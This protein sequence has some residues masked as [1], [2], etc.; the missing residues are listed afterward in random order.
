MTT[1]DVVGSPAE[2]PAGNNAESK[3]DQARKHPALEWLAKLG[4][5][6]YGVM[7][8]VVGWLALQIAFGD[9]AGEA[10]GHGA[11]REIARQPFGEVLLWVACVGFAALVAWKACEAV[12]G[13]RAEDGGK[14]VAARAASAAKAV[15][16]AVLAVLAFQTVTGSSRGGGRRSSEEGYT[17]Q[18]LQMPLGPALVVGLGVVIGGYGFYSIYKGLSDG[19]RKSLEAQGWT[20]DIGRAVTVLARTGYSTRGL[21]FGVIGG[22]FVWAGLT[23]DA[24]KSGGLDQALQTLQDAPF[25][26]ALLVAVAIGL[27]CFGVFN[28]AKAWFLRRR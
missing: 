15:V 2:N 18:L 4:T 20:G 12:A 22:L 1:S 13:H 19:W 14:R 9:P 17:A 10:S 28:V 27:A 25:G 23:H 11:L 16:F 26:K 21:A 5:A 24:D 6:V 3:A 8:V 7:Y